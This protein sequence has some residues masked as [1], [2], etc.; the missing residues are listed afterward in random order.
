GVV[1]RG[2][3]TFGLGPPTAVAGTTGMGGG[4]GIRFA[5]FDG[6]VASVGLRSSTWRGGGL[7]VSGLRFSV[8]AGYAW[9]SDRLEFVGLIGPTVAG[10]FV[11]E[12]LVQ[13]SG[14]S[15]DTAPLLGGRIVAHP[16]YVALDRSTTRLIVGLEAEASAAFEARSPAGAI[17]IYRETAQG[18]EPVARAGGFEVTIAVTVEIRFALDR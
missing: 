18:L 1:G 10:V 15:R 3:A 4:L 14:A 17:Q 8:A 7:R 12:A 6:A 11:R 2:A 13:P 16:A 9:R 5:H